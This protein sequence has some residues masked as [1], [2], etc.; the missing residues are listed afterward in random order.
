MPSSYYDAVRSVLQSGASYNFYHPNYPC[1][2]GIA[3]TTKTGT[4]RFTLSTQSLDMIIGTF[5]VTNRDTQQQ[6]M[7]GDITNKYVSTETTQEHVKH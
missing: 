4:T 7:L 6:P 3:S 5:L 1:F 2:Q